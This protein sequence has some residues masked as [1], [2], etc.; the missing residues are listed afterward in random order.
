MKSIASLSAA[1]L[2]CLSVGVR[3]SSAQNLTLP[4]QPGFGAVTCFA[5]WVSDQSDIVIKPD[6]YVLGVLDLRTPPPAMLGQNWTP[7]MY[8]HPSWTARNLGQIFG[9][10]LDG[11]GNMYVTA[12]SMYGLPANIRQTGVFGP[13]GP[14]GIYKIDRLTGEATVFATLPNT[15]PALGNICYDR[16]FRQFL[17][18]NF[19]DGAIYRIDMEGNVKGTFDPFTKD[20]G[21]SGIVGFGERLWGIGVSNGRVYYSLWKEDFADGFFAEQNE[22]WSVPLD[23][24]GNFIPSGNRRELV[25]PAY[26]WARTTGRSSAISDIAFAPDGRMMLAEVTIFRYV[27]ATEYFGRLLEYRQNG[28]GWSA[29]KMVYVGTAR[30]RTNGQGGVDYGYDNTLSP[31]QG[32]CYGSIWATGNPLVV[33]NVANAGLA[34]IPASGNTAATAGSTGFF[35][36][37]DGVLSESEYV[38]ALMGDVEIYKECC[39]G[40]LAEDTLN[41]SIADYG[42]RK[43]K[44]DI[45]IEIRLEDSITGGSPAGADFVVGYEPLSMRP[46]GMT[47]DSMTAS[48]KGTLLETWTVQNVEDNGKGSIYLSLLPPP[49]ATLA[50]TGVL[51]RIRFRTFLIIDPS[52]APDSVGK[53]AFPFTLRFAGLECT[54][55]AEKPGGVQ[56]EVCGLR[57]RLIEATLSKYSL[58]SVTVPVREF[59]EVAFSLGLDGPTTLELYDALGNRAAVLLENTQLDPGEYRITWNAADLPPGLYFYRLRSGDWEGTEKIVVKR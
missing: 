39:G 13:A 19:E 58:S 7:P 55:V 45:E 2:F 38:K 16:E 11:A 24:S 54:D 25:I 17:V 14:G 10:A 34:G 32:G 48:L 56:L 23:A 37:A 53:V 4:L 18:T 44:E 51:L 31:G 8:H 30:N 40:T 9:L 20:N 21:A 26:P 1:I 35:I 6:D 43:F 27:G 15:R 33:D 29:P 12:S 57:Y 36:D 46:L 50:D 22:L 3:P 42:A 41:V 47:P 49:G 52:I 5:G 59:G 28:T